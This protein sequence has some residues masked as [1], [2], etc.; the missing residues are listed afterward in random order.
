[1]TNRKLCRRG[2]GQGIKILTEG[3]KVYKQLQIVTV[4]R[5]CADYIKETRALD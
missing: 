5:Q 1:M 4:N 2:V 3:Q